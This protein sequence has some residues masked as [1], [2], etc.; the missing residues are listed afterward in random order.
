[1]LTISTCDGCKFLGNDW[2]VLGYSLQS[3]NGIKP[4]CSGDRR[5]G[6]SPIK[7]NLALNFKQVNKIWRL[8]ETKFL[9]SQC[10]I[11]SLCYMLLSNKSSI[12]SGP[13]VPYS[14]NEGKKIGW[15]ISI[16]PSRFFPT[17]L[18]HVVCQRML[19]FGA[20]STGLSCPMVSG[21]AK[22]RKW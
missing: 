16:C 5:H 4:L 9:E 13:Q 7:S 15:I 22:G 21:W 14:Q 12:P 19:I 1:M 2:S 17:L 8:K 18:V 6:P 11:W 20:V 10:L 3:R